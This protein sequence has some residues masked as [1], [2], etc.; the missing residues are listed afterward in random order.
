MKKELKEKTLITTFLATVTSIIFTGCGASLMPSPETL[1]N[2]SVEDFLEKQGF[3][4][5]DKEEIYELRATKN[6]KLDKEGDWT[7]SFK[8]LYH[9]R[10]TEYC[11]SKG[12]KVESPDMWQNR[13]FS[14]KSDSFKTNTMI[15]D[16]LNTNIKNW[17]KISHLCTIND[18]PLFGY[19]FTKKKIDRAGDLGVIKDQPDVKKYKYEVWY[20]RAWDIGIESNLWW[21]IEAYAVPIKPQDFEEAKLFISSYLKHNDFEKDKKAQQPAIQT[22]KNYTT[23]SSGFRRF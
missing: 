14:I 7:M 11:G 9:K 10:F 22:D 21:N 15:S 13:V 8:E 6:R 16:K 3:S 12:G 23:P 4:W 18:E 19:S 2:S 20:Q 1:K 17:G 5:D